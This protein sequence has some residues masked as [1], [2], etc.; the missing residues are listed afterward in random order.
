[1]QQVAPWVRPGQQA[2]VL[3]A[4][5]AGVQ[6]VPGSEHTPLFG[7]ASR[8]SHHSLWQMSEP[9]QSAPLAC[10]FDELHLPITHADPAQQFAA[11]VHESPLLPQAA[12]RLLLQLW[13]QHWS[14]FEHV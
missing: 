8:A 9:W 14:S 1:M 4:T 11:V 2:T 12:H 13:L 3:A 6:V 10:P 7:P 5:P